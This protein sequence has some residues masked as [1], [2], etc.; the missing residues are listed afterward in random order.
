[1]TDMSQTKT[2]FTSDRG[3]GRRKNYSKSDSNSDVFDLVLDKSYNVKATSR[4]VTSE[5]QK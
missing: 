2:K 1:M 4:K 3:G 5:K